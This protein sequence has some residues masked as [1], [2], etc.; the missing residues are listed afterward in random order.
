MNLRDRIAF[1]NMNIAF[2]NMAR[3]ITEEFVPA[4]KALSEAVDEFYE[5]A[6]R[7]MLYCILPGWIPH[8]V[9]IWLVGHWPRWLLP[10][11]IARAD[12]VSNEKR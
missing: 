3:A 4:W 6:Q 7:N 8:N 2:R 9:K 5:T 11:V 12:E 1:D 10:K